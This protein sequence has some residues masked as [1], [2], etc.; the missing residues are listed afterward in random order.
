MAA[1]ANHVQTQG[2]GLTSVLAQ[3]AQQIQQRG[4]VT[5]GLLS[6]VLNHGGGN[7]DLSQMLGGVL[8]SF[9]RS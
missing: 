1:L 9:G 7:L 5:G 2:G 8:G 6:A 3:E 4:G